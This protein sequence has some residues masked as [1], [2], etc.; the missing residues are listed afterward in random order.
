MIRD[1]NTGIALP[2]QLVLGDSSAFVSYGPNIV[3]FAANSGS[4]NWNYQAAPQTTLTLVVST[5]GGGMLAKSTY[6]NVDTMLQL[7]GSGNATPY[8]WSAP[9]ASYWAGSFYPASSSMVT[10]EYSDTVVPSSSSP[11]ER[12][13]EFGTDQATPS[14]SVTNYNN[15][16]ANQS[17][18]TEDLQLILTTLPSYPTCNNWLQGSDSFAGVSG[19]QQIQNVLGPFGAFGYGT[20]N[21]A[22]KPDYETVAFSGSTQP[23]GHTPVPGLPSNP[24]PVLTV[25]TIG[26]FFNATSNQG[27][28]YTL[29]PNRY[30][31]NTL[32][33]QL[34][35]LIH[36]TAHQ[37]TVNG[38]LPDAGKPL[39]GAANDALVNTH[40]KTLI[41]HPWIF[42]LS[43]G[44]GAAG[45]RVTINGG[46]FLPNRGNSF[47]T[48]YN[49]AAAN[50][51]SWS[52]SQIVVTIPNGAATGANYII[53]TV[54]GTASNA[55]SFIV[56]PAP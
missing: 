35:T 47:V 14:Y 7:D 53:V 43:V 4:V 22:N 6:E 54:G 17:I 37:I 9:N 8:S 31:G 20:F 1:P 45:T 36:E 41:E 28:A 33:A 29:G 44:S 26:L 21:I 50:V 12:L 5:V 27:K 38:F 48:F 18:I 19:V 51:N 46:N 3:S 49:G 16:G 13:N 25:N 24:A 30:P 32:R 34:A 55:A 42:S 15:T 23:P 10:T 56:N 2:L 11:W 52:D 40:C 39:I